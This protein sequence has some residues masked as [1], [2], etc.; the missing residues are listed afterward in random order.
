MQHV[1]LMS[2]YSRD[3]LCRE[4]ALTVDTTLESTCPQLSW[5]CEHTVRS[6][7]T[8]LTKQAVMQAQPEAVMQAQP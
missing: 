5:I 6:I 8:K 3:A 4:E 1:N 2:Y 7:V